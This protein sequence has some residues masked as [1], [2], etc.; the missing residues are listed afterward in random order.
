MLVHP[1]FAGLFFFFPLLTAFK[2][3]LPKVHTIKLMQRDLLTSLPFE[4]GLS[5]MPPSQQ[6]LPLFFLHCYFIIIIKNITISSI[7]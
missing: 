7:T 5:G 4:T 1:V 3:S 6:L 2:T